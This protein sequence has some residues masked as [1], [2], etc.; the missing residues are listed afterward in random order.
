[1]GWLI[2]PEEQAVLVFLSP[3]RVRA[4][5]M[6]DQRIPTPEF[7]AAVQLTVE[8]LFGWLSVR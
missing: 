3:D 6:K 5:E 2:D 7:A 1:M 4:F 8:E